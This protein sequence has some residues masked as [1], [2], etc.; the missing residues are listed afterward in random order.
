LVAEGVQLL[1]GLRRDASITSF[2]GW[3]PEPVAAHAAHA[4]RERSLAL[5]ARRGGVRVGMFSTGR[6]RIVTASDRRRTRIPND[7]TESSS[8][9]RYGRAIS[10]CLC[11]CN[12]IADPE[13]RD[14]AA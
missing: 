3:P 5:P 14:G 12:Y 11:A 13:G 8:A 2:A 1:V 10:A 4:H 6:R 7:S 9:P